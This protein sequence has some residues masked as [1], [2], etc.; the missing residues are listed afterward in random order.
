VVDPAARQG[1]KSNG[2]GFDGH[3][4]HVAIDPDSE[5]ITAAEF[6]A[7][8]TGDAAMAPVLLADLPAP[9]D[10]GVPPPGIAPSDQAAATTSQYVP[11]TQAPVVYGDAAYGTGALLA[12]LDQRG[13]TAMTKVAAPPPRTATSPSSSSASTWTPARSP[14]RRG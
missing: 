11:A 9:A 8:N 13:I 7:A 5:V 12:E 10:A 2:R 1:H 3:K 4:G 6:G 14:A